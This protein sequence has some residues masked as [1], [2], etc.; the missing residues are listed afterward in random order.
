MDDI[1]A[2]IDTSKQA[3]KQ[4]VDRAQNNKLECRPGRTMLESFEHEVNQVLNK[5]RD[6]AVSGG[7]VYLTG[8]W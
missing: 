3:V 5:A 1:V 6:T 2:T 8:T 7:Q 4:L